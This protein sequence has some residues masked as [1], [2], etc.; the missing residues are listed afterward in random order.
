[1][2][3]ALAEEKAKTPSIKEELGVYMSAES[4]AGLSRYLQKHNIVDK[5]WSPPDK[6]TLKG[7]M[8]EVDHY[9]YSPIYGERIA[10]RL[11]GVLKCKDGV[12]GFGR[13]SNMSGELFD[14]DFETSVLLKV[15]KGASDATQQ[16]MVDMPT[17]LFRSMAL[18]GQQT[19]ESSLKWSGSVPGGEVLGVAYAPSS[20][21]TMERFTPDVQLVIDG[22]ICSNKYIDENCACGFDKADIPDSVPDEVLKK[23]GMRGG[24]GGA[25]STEKEKEQENGGGGDDNDDDDDNDDSETCPVC[26]FMKK[27]PCAHAFKAWDDCVQGLKEEEDLKKCFGL[28]VAMMECMQQH[29]YYDIMTANSTAKMDALDEAEKAEK[30]AAAV[31]AADKK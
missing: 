8:D 4:K 12:V 15:N 7:R 28:T 26:R 20:T 27:G 25:A 13:L 1:M 11:K 24:S 16:A 17:L 2:S 18:S 6:I 29:E 22:H 19:R 30:E 3:T 5:E 31:A 10:F 21:V 9:V 23:R 14:D